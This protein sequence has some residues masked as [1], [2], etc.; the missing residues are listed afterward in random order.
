MSECL[1]FVLIRDY[2]DTSIVITEQILAQKVKNHF[3]KRM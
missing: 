2:E 1:A 3:E